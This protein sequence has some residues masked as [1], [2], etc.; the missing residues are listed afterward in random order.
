MFF[1][2]QS[3]YKTQLDKVLVVKQNDCKKIRFLLHPLVTKFLHKA[4]VLE[5]FNITKDKISSSS[6]SD[7]AEFL[8]GAVLS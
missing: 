8:A 6:D 1:I 3:W 4:M 2:W 7:I 5:T